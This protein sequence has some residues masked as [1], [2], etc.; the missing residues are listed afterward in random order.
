[1]PEAPF[2]AAPATSVLAALSGRRPMRQTELVEQVRAYSPDVDEDLLN[3]AY[4]FALQAHG[5]QTRASGDPYFSHPVEVAGILTGLKL[6]EASIAAALLHDT[7]EDTDATEPELTRLFGAEVAQLVCGV[8]KLTR[9]EL[10]SD[11]TKQ[12]ENFRKLILAMSKDIRVLLIKLADRLH[13]MRTLHFIKKPEKRRRIALET[14]EIFAP[15]AERIGMSEMK[16]ELEEL[17]FRQ[18]EPDSYDAIVERLT[19]VRAADDN[20]V[21]RI[22]A[23]LQQMMDDNDLPADVSGR[24]KSPYSIWRKM[25]R[26]AIRFEQL[27]DIMAFRII[28]ADIPSCY[29]ALGVVHGAFRMIPDRF[30]DFISNPKANGY[31][32]LHTTVL[33]PEGQAIEVQIRTAE[34]HE[35]AIR[36]VA[37]HWAYKAHSHGQGGDNTDDAERYK[38]LRDVLEIVETASHPDEFLDYT[39]LELF[40][41]QVFCFTPRGD[42][43]NLPRNATPL[44]FAYAVHSE[45]GNRCVG[46]KVN[47]RMVPLPTPLANGDQVDILTSKNQTPSPDWLDLVTTGK[48]KAHIR[49]FMRQRQRGEHAALGRAMLQRVFKAEGVELS[50]KVLKDGLDRLRQDSIEDVLAGVGDGTLSGREV[51]S[52]L[53]PSHRTTEAQPPTEDPQ[54][55]PRPR[56]KPPAGAPLAI[57]GLIPGMAV[58]YAKCCHPIPGDRIVGIITT[59]KGVTIHTIDCDMLASFAETPERWLDVSWN[60]GADD[61]VHVGRLRLLIANEKG[62]LASLSSLIAKNNGNIVNLQ[63]RSRS[64]DFWDMAIDVEVSDAKHLVHIIAALRALKSV[65]SVDREKGR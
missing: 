35:I 15:L 62:N 16:E 2:A 63:L 13:N 46:A 33:W 24:E 10:Q 43:I 60:D 59:G 27:S 45:V 49:R 51:F 48:A 47:G 3:R 22:I 18:A 41:D 53:F 56:K 61:Q 57:S 65:I 32:S 1:M 52:T 12:A 29:Q 36:G 14:L 21:P 38:W 31:A 50:D 6:D 40:P 58:H 17:A 39:K 4:V 54:V 30:K 5:G 7:I 23:H 8:T 9:L 20:L 34:M 55:G 26:K 25:Q 19:A 44:D 42:V 11:Q 37:A 64:V 28:V